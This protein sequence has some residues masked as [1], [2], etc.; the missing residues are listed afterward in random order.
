MSNLEQLILDLKESLGHQIGDLQQQIAGLDRA[1]PPRSP[2]LTS[3]FPPRS[4]ALTSA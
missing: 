3:A 4:S 2:A 1:F